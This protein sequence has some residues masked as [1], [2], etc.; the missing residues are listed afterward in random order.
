MRNILS[1]GAEAIIEQEDDKVNKRRIPKSYRIKEID[2]SLRKSRTKRE[3]KVLRKCNELGINVPDVFMSDEEAAI[4]MSFIDGRRLR[5]EL[6]DKPKEAKLLAIVGEWMAKLHENTIIHGDLTTSN[7]MIDKEG[8]LF[9]IDFGLSFF[10]TKIEDMAVDLHLFEQALES[11]HY[12]YKDEFFDE[13]LKGYSKFEK[14]GEVIK[15]L[16][17]VRARGRNKH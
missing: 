13:F 11:T 17:V 16:E 8:K 10:S 15:R 12:L 4:R 7:I 9:L 6:L 1:Q 2:L 14:S 3:E 5:D